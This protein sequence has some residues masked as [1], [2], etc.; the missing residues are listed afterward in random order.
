MN[1]ALA[2]IATAL[3]L[4]LCLHLSSADEAEGASA[5]GAAHLPKGISTWVYR[6][7]DGIA[8]QVH[9]FNSRARRDLRFRYFFPYAGSLSFD[10]EKQEAAVHYRPGSTRAYAAALPPDVRLFPTVDARA[11]EGE[12]S[13]W[14]EERYRAAARAVAAH[15]IADPNAAG[16]QIDI[17]PFR[18]D[19]LPFYRYLTE[20]IN[21]EGKY[22]TMFV[23]P[24]RKDLLTRIFESCDIVVMSGYDLNGE[25]MPLERYRASMTGAVARFDEVAEETSRHYMIGIPAAASWGEFE[26][27][28]CKDCDRIETGVRQEDYVRAALEAVAPYHESPRYLGVALWHM[29]DPEEEVEDPKR[30]TKRTKFPNTIRESVWQLLE[31]Y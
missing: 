13:G 31:D 17:E 1:S 23:G 12:F 8:R 5:A 2:G 7:S 15:L 6:Y 22:C 27:S 20:E 18:A 30:P 26:Y 25:G 14:S 21:R 9:R 11:D 24:K 19:H 29:S 10:K 3:V 16:V 4:G 28:D